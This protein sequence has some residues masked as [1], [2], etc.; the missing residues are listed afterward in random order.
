MIERNIPKYYIV[1]S[2][3]AH[4]AEKF[5]AETIQKY[6]YKSTG[7]CYPLI[8]DGISPLSAEIM[9]GFSARGIGKKITIPELGEEG[10]VIKNVDGNIVIGGNTPRA[11]LYGAVAFLEKTIGFKAFTKNVETYEKKDESEISV[12]DTVEKPDFEYRDAFFRDAFDEDFCIKNKLNTSSAFISDRKGGSK[13]FFTIGHTFGALLPPSEYFSEHPEYYALV[14]GKR[15]P[16]Q[17][18][19]TNP[20]VFE[21]IKENLFKQIR[22][23]P[24][25]E[26]FSVAQNDVDVCC[27]CPECRKI[28]E[29]EESKAGT[30]IFFVNK[31]AREVKKAFPDVLLHTFAYRF[32]RK[33]PKNLIPEDNVIVRLCNIECDWSEPFPVL[34][35]N[36]NASAI[37]FDRNLKEWG[38]ITKRLYVWD[39]AVNFHNYPLPFPCVYQMA[40]NIR[41]FKKCG[42]TGVFEQGNYSRGGG[43][44]LDDLKSYLIAKTLWDSDTDP[45]ETVHDFCKNVYGKGGKYVERYLDIMTE[46]VKGKTLTLYDKPSAPYFSD[47]LTERC[48]ELF[49]KALKEA[50]NEQIR[51]R[52][53][54]EK[55]SVDY[56]TI[57]RIADEKERIEKTNEFAEKLVKYGITEIMEMTA[58]DDSLNFMRYSRF[59]EERFHRY[60]YLRF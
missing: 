57:V 40:E 23:N 46:A 12:S 36:G 33:A 4:P 18:C 41:Y 43:V 10:Y 5:A 9:V 54:K 26:I 34:V 24:Q 1:A 38:R 30:N 8:N 39:Y 21:I 2:A 28:N 31:L 59:T 13:R 20:D 35:K 44:S 17:P 16:D 52:I 19:L 42:V 7:K 32:T 49:E 6:L 22:E 48:N 58:L 60:D 29:N 14:D 15:T 50:E 47:E 3:K 56:M 25:C 53:E 11:T 55:L 51:D 45:K 37:E 27:D